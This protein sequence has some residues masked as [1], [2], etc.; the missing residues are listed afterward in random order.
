[1]LFVMNRTHWFRYHEKVWSTDMLPNIG[2]F[3]VRGNQRT[4]TI[5]DMAWAKYQVR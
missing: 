4:F 1:M 5:F 2:L 3:L